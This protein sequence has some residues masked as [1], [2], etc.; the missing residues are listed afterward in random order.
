LRDVRIA[1][2]G[3]EAGLCVDFLSICRMLY[4]I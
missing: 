2:A 3:G 4:V 1:L